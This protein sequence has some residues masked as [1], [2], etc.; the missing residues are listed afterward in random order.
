[1]KLSYVIL[2]GMLAVAIGAHLSNF[3]SW[4]AVL[5]VK[6]IGT[7]IASIGSVIGAWLVKSPFKG[8]NGTTPAKP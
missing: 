6:A 5:S 3:D 1:M 7:L 8:T 4:Q 2:V